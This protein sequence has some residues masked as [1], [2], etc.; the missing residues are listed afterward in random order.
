MVDLD[1]C[2]TDLIPHDASPDG[3]VTA[4][5]DSASCPAPSVS[6]SFLPPTPVSGFGSSVVSLAE[7]VNDSF[8]TAKIEPVE[9]SDVS[10]R[11]TVNVDDPELPTSGG[12]ALVSP[13]NCA[14][15][16]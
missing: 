10:S 15:S 9:A 7:S 14:T 4:L 5:Q 2:E 11:V 16:V 1:R 6:V 13:S 12:D 8:E 3:S